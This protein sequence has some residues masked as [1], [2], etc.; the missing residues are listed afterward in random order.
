MFS[1]LTQRFDDRAADRDAATRKANAED[2]IDIV[3]GIDQMTCQVITD[4][5][6]ILGVMRELCKHKTPLRLS[7]RARVGGD[8]R[9]IAA[10]PQQLALRQL[11]QPGASEAMR[12]DGCVNLC[13]D[14]HG[15]PLLMT[16]DLY[17]DIEHEGVPCH[18]ADMPGWLLFAEM[19]QRIRVS[20]PMHL[21]A[22]AVI[23]LP[24]LEP[25]APPLQA[26][27]LDVSESGLGLELKP[28]PQQAQML[29]VGQL[30]PFTRLRTRDG[31]FGLVD[32]K[33]RYINKLTGGLRIG[34]SIELADEPV[35]QALRRLVLLQQT[36]ARRRGLGDD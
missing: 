14:Y 5:L 10:D 13:T 34:A 6:R 31:D 24:G 2:V 36:N 21:G 9:I 19:R 4:P 1:F 28:T 33:V 3:S 29:A 16:L 12:R 30:W 18:R 7:G 20:L 8:S 17:D 23:E 25:D 22:E 32:L 11:R 15:S 26:R 27:I 35:R